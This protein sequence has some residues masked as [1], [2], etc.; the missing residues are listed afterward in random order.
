MKHNYND[1]ANNKLWWF[2]TGSVSFY[3][4][5]GTVKGKEGERKGRGGNIWGDRMRYI[6]RES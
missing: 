4:G 5:V 1:K 3:L 6:M 2:L